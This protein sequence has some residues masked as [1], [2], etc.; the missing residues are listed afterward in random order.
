GKK[1]FRERSL[2]HAVGSRLRMQENRHSM[3]R[4]GFV[5]LRAAAIMLFLVLLPSVSHAGDFVVFG[6]Q[7]YVRRTGTPT[8]I[9]NT[10]RAP[11]V[12]TTLTMRIDSDRVSSAVVTLNGVEI[13][14]SSDFNAGV[15]L[16]T[17]PV[18]LLANNQ[19]TVEIRGIPDQGFTI[20]IVGTDDTP[21]TIAAAVSPPPSS[22]GWNKSNPT[23]TF[24]CADTISGVDFCQEPITVIAET[25]G[26]EIVG[27]AIDK[28]GNVATT[29]VTVKLDRTPTSL[30]L[31]S[32]AN[33][34]RSF[35]QQI[36]LSGTASDGLSG[37]AGVSCNGIPAALTGNSFSCSVTL[38]PGTSP[39]NVIAT[40]VAGNS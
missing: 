18:T 8:P 35:V 13:F 3:S 27:T 39:V 4:L 6:P 10:F 34:T 21:P 7:Q 11:D 37:L 2:S 1:T 12:L 9:T 16:L 5:V 36:T 23:V 24:T 20:Q 30:S 17:K 15:Q 14:S 28:A 31:T 32:P 38:T 25:S 19:L 40:D 33:L 22:S 29:S 26:Q